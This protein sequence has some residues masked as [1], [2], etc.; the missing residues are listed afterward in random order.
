MSETQEK[1][2][3]LHELIIQGSSY[4]IAVLAWNYLAFTQP[5]G[6]RQRGYGPASPFTPHSSSHVPCIQPDGLS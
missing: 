6:G 3:D 5:H 2:P 1:S 4:P